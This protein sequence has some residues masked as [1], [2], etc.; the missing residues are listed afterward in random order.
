[1]NTTLLC[2]LYALNKHTLFNALL[3]MIFCLCFFHVVTWLLSS[4]VRIISLMPMFRVL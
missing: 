2:F 4:M 3:L 1:M